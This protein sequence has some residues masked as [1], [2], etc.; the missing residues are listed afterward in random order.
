MLTFC[1]DVYTGDSI[2]SREFD[3]FGHAVEFLFEI[4]N[5]NYINVN[6]YKHEENCDPLPCDFTGNHVDA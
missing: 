4:E 1:V 2:F 6:I 3:S 5:S